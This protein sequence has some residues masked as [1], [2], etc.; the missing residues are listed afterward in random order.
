MSDLIKHRKDIDGL[1]A[2]AIMSVVIFH[3]KSSLLPSGFVGVDI[4]FV[5]SGFLI[6]KIILR[7]LETDKFSFTQFY[8]RRIRRIF[9]ALFTV[10]LF[11]IA[12][13]ALTL[14]TENLS[15][16]CKT[17]RYAVAQISNFLFQ[18]KVGYFDIRP[19]NIPLLHTWSLAVEE[20][21]YLVFPLFLFFL[22]KLKKNR[23]FIFY[24][25]V[26]LSLLSLALS[27]YL[28]INSPKVAFF[29]LPSRFWEL[30][31]GAI[32][33]FQKIK[34]LSGKVNEA[35]GIMGFLL[36]AVSFFVISENNFPAIYAIMPCLGAALVIF[37][38][39]KSDTLISKI[40][41]NKI[42]VFLGIISYSLYLWHYPIIA[43]YKEFMEVK[44]LQFTAIILLFSFS[45]AVSYLSYK[46]IETPFRK[47]KSLQEEAFINFAKYRI[48]RPFSASIICITF[49]LLILFDIKDQQ[50]LKHMK[51]F[52]DNR[53]ND[54]HRDCLLNEDSIFSEDLVEKCTEGKNK[55]GSQVL[56]IGDSHGFRYSR[57]L[58]DWS[59]KNNYSMIMLASTNCPSA[60]DNGTEFCQ[61]L[62]DKIY[63]VV[64]NN[65]KLKYVV[66]A[67]SWSND[68]KLGE[69]F[70]QQSLEKNIRYFTEQGKRVVI[71]GTVPVFN[72]DPVTC[73]SKNHTPIYEFFTSL[74]NQECERES[75][76]N[77]V[78]NGELLEKA[79]LEMKAKYGVKY[80]DPKP[81][82]CD[83]QY[84]YSVID[85]KIF[86]TDNN[87]LSFYGS[88]YVGS[89]FNF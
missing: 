5:I 70:A 65:K 86:Y 48:Y 22:T 28:L 55:N 42:L 67:N 10:L 38:G 47:K 39:E 2:L 6:T 24:S 66:L 45:V 36:I 69:D 44:E 63:E 88:S 49:F 17:A 34:P 14:D 82:L 32:L 3:L 41:A 20:Q 26:G 21:F 58:L 57:G 4:F 16:F 89:Y 76:K 75:I 62:R 18:K 30:G 53:G 51:I 1:R 33:A 12:F 80:F 43:F 68:V 7:E 46:Y 29:S 73:L 61:K 84:C 15:W 72:F 19:E 54:F 78:P 59:K 13:A 77:V 31:L 23:N 74:K 85:G 56:L 52:G 50:E 83:Q 79:F 27:Q 8:I 37:S 71:L 25:L 35:T 9:P 81:Y 87:H 40:L 11:S 64:R 60:I